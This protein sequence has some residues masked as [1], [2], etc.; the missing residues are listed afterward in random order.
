[1]S[2]SFQFAVFLFFAATLF[3]GIP[4]LSVWMIV[5]GIITGSIR[6]KYGRVNLNESPKA[7]WFAVF[8]YALGGLFFIS[9]P[10]YAFIEIAW[11]G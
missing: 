9:L 11:T 5:N 2:Q 7:F 3:L 4:V 8:F 1:M 6:T 10:L